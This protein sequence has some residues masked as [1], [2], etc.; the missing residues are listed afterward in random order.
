MHDVLLQARG[1]AWP[2]A[3]VVFVR[4]EVKIFSQFEHE[5]ERGALRN[6]S[7]AVN[8]LQ[9]RVSGGVPL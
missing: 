3:Q 9:L 5:G 8:A 4:G 6:A 2:L 1:D 7:P